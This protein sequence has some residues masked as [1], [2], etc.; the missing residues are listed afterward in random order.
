MFERAH[1]LIGA[2]RASHAIRLARAAASLAPTFWQSGLNLGGILIDGGARLRKPVLVRE[3]IKLL[4]SHVEH[5]PDETR[6]PFHYNIGTGYSELGARERGHGPLTRPSTRAA[7]E[8]L[9]QAVSSVEETP[10]QWVNLAGALSVQGRY[11]EAIDI[12]SA[13]LREYPDHHQALATRSN[14]QTRMYGW[15]WHHRGLLDSAALDMMLALESAMHTAPDYAIR[16]SG[17]LGNL[18]GRIGADRPH[19]TLREPTAM[20]SWI[21]ENGLALN[22]CPLC[23]AERPDSIDTYVVEGFLE[24]PSRRPRVEEIAETV[25]SWHR[26]FA[27]ARWQL[28][29][30]MGFAGELPA[31]HVPTLGGLP[32]SDQGLRVGLLAS[33]LT[34]FHAI[35][36]Q[37]AFGINAILRLGHDPGKVN[38]TSVWSKR[39]WKQRQQGRAAIPDRR[40]D[41]HPQLRRGASRSLA[42][43]FHLSW[44]FAVGEGMYRS[45]RKLRDRAA[46]HVIVAT[47]EDVTS[48]V[49]RTISV[50]EL[51]RQ[52]AAMGRLAKAAMWYAGGA[53]SW[54]EAN[55]LR[56]ARR[57]GEL[58]G[59]GAPRIINRQ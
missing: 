7:V 42:A 39:G 8:H 26:S 31:D 47:S 35:L 57:E 24:A 53:I 32:G 20:Q 30:A 27:T 3:G 16:Y 15:M 55:R 50:T 41:I 12:L 51:E 25:N 4:E 19:L 29:Q 14:A 21:Y 45:L 46:H 44:S 18:H 43:L 23:H 17:A 28:V 10:D 59:A 34:E 38:F 9:A 54:Y 13:V 40:E 36:D 37:I 48:S 33:A 56:R 22:N 11:V 52:A 49:V 6:R 2:G 5:A 58:V 1:A